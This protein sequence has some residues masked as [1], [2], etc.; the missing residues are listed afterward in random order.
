MLAGEEKSKSV[1]FAKKKKEKAE[2]LLCQ[3]IFGTNIYVCG[4]DE[5]DKPRCCCCCCCRDWAASIE[6]IL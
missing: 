4:Q 1:R 6:V 2:W 5:I 3:T